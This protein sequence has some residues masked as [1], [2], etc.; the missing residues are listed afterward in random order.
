MASLF[1]SHRRPNLSPRKVKAHAKKLTQ[2]LFPRGYAGEFFLCGGAFKPLI[3]PQLKINDLDLWVRNRKSREQ[4]VS[5]LLENGAE[6]VQ[7]FVPHCIKLQKDDVTVEI[8]YHNVNDGSVTDIIEG[9][10]LACSAIGVR[11]DSGRIHDA[12]IS[13]GLLRSL[14]KKITLLQEGFVDRVREDHSPS[15]LRS[16]D[17]MKLFASDAGFEIDT[18]SND[19]LWHLF[20]TAYDEDEKQQSLDLYMETT[21]AYKSRCDA[22]IL[23]RA[24][25][26]V[27]HS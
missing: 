24:N 14:E 17:R 5:A 19:Q 3:D 12:T 22:E 1:Y 13:K 2:F 10:D 8:T 25:S 11:Y 6:L 23:Q 26:C 21:V 9:F 7:D 15:L 20:E 27:L 16:I 4:L 18:E